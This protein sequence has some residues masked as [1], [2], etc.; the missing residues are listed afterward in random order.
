MRL[1]SLP[2]ALTIILCLGLPAGLF[3]AGAFD[4]LL[5]AIGFPTHSVDRERM[6]LYGEARA[7]NWADLVQAQDAAGLARRL[8]GN[9][10]S[11][12][13]SHG[14]LLGKTGQPLPEA[15][16]ELPGLAQRL[17][18]YGDLNSAPRR[19][20]DSMG[21]FGNLRAL[22]PRGGEL[23]ADL[24]GSIVTI[25]GFVAPLAFDG[26]RMAEFL[27]VPYVGACIHVPPPPANQIVFIS[28]PGDYRPDQGLLYP[29]RVTGRLRV[30]LRETDLANVGYQIEQAVVERYEQPRD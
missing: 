8:D 9:L 5:A 27:L 18:G 6:K 10:A 28:D 4:G 22:Q 2:T 1:K 19:L 3:A 30:H 17:G 25:A 16:V 26:S 12:I 7:L 21:G 14:D 23:R 13:V 11:G 15:G 20:S 29:V 24:D